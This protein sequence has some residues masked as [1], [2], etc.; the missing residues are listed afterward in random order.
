MALCAGIDA[1]TGD[2]IVPIDVDL[3]DPPELILEFLEKW[4]AGFDV[5]YGIRASRRGDAALK[6][7]SAAAFYKV[8][9]AL[10]DVRMPRNAGDFRMMDRTVVDV[11][12]KLP[13]RNRFMKGLFAWVGFNQIGIPYIRP[14][15]AGGKS[16]WR[17]W[18]LWNFAL[19]GLTSF[20][21]VPLRVWTYIG[22]LAAVV[23]F[24]YGAFLIMN[25]LL[26]GIDVPGY[27]SLMVVML[28]GFG[29]QM[30]AF[31][32]I[33]EYLSRIFAEVKARPLY[34]ARK[35]YGFEG[36]A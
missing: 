15:R 22:A 35:R 11:I 9:D 13:E 23:S 29:I 5:V 12:R 18:R 19:D 32:V 17:Y 8:F 4:E 16:A 6:Q 21:T 1:A 3:Q 26:K 33:G 30:V 20:S 27:A 34:V 36:E 10:S 7:L 2:M 31:G 14:E 28:F 24:A 25:V